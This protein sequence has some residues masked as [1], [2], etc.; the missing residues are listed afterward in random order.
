MCVTSLDLL[1]GPRVDLWPFMG[2]YVNGFLSCVTYVEFGGDWS[3]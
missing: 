3:S 1:C 2:F